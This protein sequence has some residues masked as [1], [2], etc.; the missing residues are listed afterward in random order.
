[1]KSLYFFFL[2]N[3]KN[4]S[5]RYRRNDKSN[6]RSVLKRD[7]KVFPVD[8]SRFIDRTPIKG[9]HFFFFP[10]LDRIEL[11]ITDGK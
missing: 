1:M 11:K 2:L 7:S 5:D 8:F 6:S 10:P 9:E 4:Q 3:A